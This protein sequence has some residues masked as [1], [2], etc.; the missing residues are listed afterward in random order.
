M[1]DRGSH[2]RSPATRRGILGGRAARRRRQAYIG[3]QLSQGNTLDQIPLA[4][5][6]GQ[7]RPWGTSRHWDPEDLASAS[8]DTEVEEVEEEEEEEEEEGE[9]V[10]VIEIPDEEP[11]VASSA[12][13]S[14]L[15]E[16]SSKAV[17]RPAPASSSTS[18]VV[19]RPSLSA[20]VVPETEQEVPA[21]AVRRNIKVADS[22][23]LFA[24]N[25]Y[26]WKTQISS[27]PIRSRTE[28]VVAIDWHQVTD[29]FRFGER[30]VARVSNDYKLPEGVLE[31]YREVS[32]AK[33]PGDVFVICSHIWKSQTNLDNL[34]WTVKENNLPVDLVIV[35]S[36][37]TGKEGKL[38]TLAALTP[39]N[40]RLLLL[41]DNS[42]IK[43]L[44]IR[45]PRK[46][47]VSDWPEA[48]NV[49]EH[50]GR[51]REFLSV[52]R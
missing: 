8:E 13:S 46:P 45:V 38:H 50:V 16:P 30:S 51:A 6:G 43:F 14:R 23:Q 35:T 36:E 18:R 39:F 19:I 4:R 3:Y 12:S 2:S 25:Q 32:A 44:H 42:E 22:V 40:T 33:R 26:H 47:R 11:V 15:T 37:R 31:F 7:Q 1:V 28:R 27:F 49:L 21:E 52:D 10:E 29:T 34:L 17:S 24:V 5:P 41:D 9:A 20:A 48:W